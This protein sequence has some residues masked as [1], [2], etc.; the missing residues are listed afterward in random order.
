MDRVTC[1]CRAVDG[2]R[3]RLLSHASALLAPTASVGRASRGPKR[4][5][6]VLARRRTTVVL[7]RTE[8]AARRTMGLSFLSRVVIAG[9]VR[10]LPCVLLV[11]LVFSGGA[12]AAGG[13]AWKPL[14]RLAPAGG[15][16][17]GVSC[18]SRG[19]CIAV[20]SVDRA[21][22]AEVWDGFRWSVLPTRDPR[23]SSARLLGVSC[24]SRVACMAVGFSTG[25][26]GRERA[27]AER[28]DGLKWSIQRT[29]DPSHRVGLAAVS[30]ASATMC[31]AVGADRNFRDPSITRGFGFAL[32]EHWN[33][34]RWAIQATPAPSSAP[35]ASDP[36]F[37][38][39]CVSPRACTAVGAAAVGIVQQGVLLGFTRVMRALRWNGVAW[40]VLPTPVEN[41]ASGRLD[42][43]NA[44]SCVSRSVCF[45]VGD[46]GG[47]DG[48]AVLW[49]GDTP[50]ESI[51]PGSGFRRE[52]AGVSCVAATSCVAVGTG[53]RTVRHQIL[54]GWNGTTWSDE[55]PAITAALDLYAVSCTSRTRCVAVGRSDN[56][57]AYKSR[58]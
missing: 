28:W 8:P 6:V 12:W 58:L 40:S 43:L 55:R 2:V 27:L 16:F 45:A 32:V 24:A 14:H 41:P 7:G 15:S 22:L 51:L 53:I 3:S 33:G 11:G 35:V 39:S 49:N 50:S 21:P 37:G 19:L 38:V 30:C 36:L 31:T 56:R 42:E 34:S 13:S 23:G 9:G 47:L 44:V 52:L 26:H 46:D 29:P 57:P 54:Y 17:S 1:R 20:G 5:H 18:L 48:L 4:Q 25:A 10:G